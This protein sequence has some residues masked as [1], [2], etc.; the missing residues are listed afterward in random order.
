MKFSK[1]NRI[2]RPSFCHWLGWLF[3]RAKLDTF[4]MRSQRDARRRRRQS[5]EQIHSSQSFYNGRQNMDFRW[6]SA[7]D[8]TTTTTKRDDHD[9]ISSNQ[10]NDANQTSF[11]PPY[12]KPISFAGLISSSFASAESQ[13]SPRRCAGSPLIPSPYHIPYQMSRCGQRDFSRSLSWC[14]RIATSR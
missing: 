8:A 4:A 12:P 1:T 7:D 11:R 5:E 2:V 6:S 14:R 9:F 10:M 13:S 3:V